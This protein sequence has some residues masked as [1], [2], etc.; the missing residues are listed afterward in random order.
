MQKSIC[1]IIPYFGRWPDWFSFY[2]KSCGYNRSV[3]WMI[4][5]NCRI[6]DE[7]PDNVRFVNMSLGSFN[8]LAS[9]KLRIKINIEKPYKVCDLRPAFGLIFE[10]FISDYNFWGNTDI[11]II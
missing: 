1:L 3:N 10:D 9:E 2:L 5:T 4:F 8:R 6:P 7:R 11:D